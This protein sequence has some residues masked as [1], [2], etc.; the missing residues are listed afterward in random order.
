[1]T[2]QMLH[3]VSAAHDLNFCALRYFNVAGADPQARTGQS[4]AG[5]T[6]LIKVAV[7][8]ALGKRGSPTTSV[9]RL[10]KGSVIVFDDLD[11]WWER[12]P[13]GL[14]AIDAILDLV[15]GAGERV[16]F[17]LAGSEAPLRVIQD[18]RPLSRL[19]YTRLD[20][21]PL[22]AR[23]LEKVIVA[24]HGSTGIDLK[25][26]GRRSFSAWTRA[27]LFDAHFAYT[28]GNVGYALRSWITHLESFAD[29][30]L[31]IRMP[32]PLDWDA[33]DDLRPE[34]LALLIELILHKAA[35]VE[36]L[37]RLTGRSAASIADGLAELTAI[38]LV[39]QNRR[40]IAQLNP[41]VHV[42]VLRWL[43]R[44]ELA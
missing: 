4:T 27:R 43:D 35:T 17:I 3:D 25:I 12:R 6:H 37:E 2:E 21:Q 33:I 40:R 9:E 31:T 20:C 38:D 30:Q 39:V 41:F 8:A 36:K 11:L 42:P 29:D 1:M 16:G 28:H 44:K 10:P 24:R 19:V 18:L 13:G 26:A 34:Y 5:A 32:R 15:A 23:E 22:S 14:E 7:E